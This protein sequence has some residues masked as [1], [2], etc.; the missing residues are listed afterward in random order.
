MQRIFYILLLCVFPLTLSAQFNVERV[1]MSGRAALYYEDYVLSIQYFNQ[2]LSL[3]PFLWEPWQLRAIAKYSLEDFNGAVDDATHAISLNPYISQTYD[4]RA[5]SRIRLKEYTAAIDDYTMAIK[6]DPSKKEYWHNRALCRM[7]TKDYEQASAD[8]DTIIMRWE[9]YLPV[10][11]MKADISLRQK[12]TLKAETWV[13]KALEIDAYSAEAWRMKGYLSM[14]REEWKNAESAFS[15]VLHFRPKQSD[16]YLNRAVVRL[17]QN[18]LRGAMSDYDMALEF[19]PTNFLGHYNRG[20]LR[21][22]VGD[23]NRAIEDF[24]FVLSLEP[25]N[26]M[27]LFNRATLLDRT[28]DLRGAIRDYSKVIKEFP[29]FWTGLHYRAGCYRRLGMTAKA[30]MDEFRIL[31]AQMDKH[32]GKQP[33]WSRKKL[34]EI[35]KK[36]DVDPEKYNQIVV[37]DEQNAAPEYKSEYRGKVQNRRVDA[38]YQPYIIVSTLAYENALSTNHKPYSREVDS[39]NEHLKSPKLYLST[40]PSQ[41][42]EEKLREEFV[43]IDS[44]T[45]CISNTTDPNEAKYLLMARCAA[46]AVTQNY[47][48]AMNDADLCIA[49]D[50]ASVLAWW[51]R[52]VCNARLAEYEM[53]SSKLN[54]NLRLAGV[55]ADFNKAQL[56]GADNVY[57]YY[58]RGTFHA[59]RDEYALALEYLDKAI[60]L[61]QYFPEAYF[62]RGLVNLRYGNRE[63]GI[64]DLGKAGELGLYSAYSI[65]KSNSK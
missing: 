15:K 43:L 21:Q 19:D 28:G 9:H 55:I 64:T 7:E 62:N 24:D 17:K 35:R 47:Q 52:A 12:D 5:V 31:K 40:L 42:E 65:I 56:Y 22:Q 50:S 38:V 58:C 11:L 36:S 10:Y 13:D 8:A 14:N 33:R 26:M 34:S 4:L 54:T 45:N 39:L 16:C 59:M 6:H 60:S 2:A 27:A 30:E 51:Q 18:N 23:D 48:D 3:K 57:V 44:L 20:L 37:D 63:K 41:L 53:Q 32:L 1:I 49:V 46:N 25:D 29:N 61:D